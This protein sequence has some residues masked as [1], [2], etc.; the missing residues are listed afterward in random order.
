MAIDLAMIP[1]SKELEAV[2]ERILTDYLADNPGGD[3]AGYHRVIDQWIKNH[4]EE[5]ERLCRQPLREV[6]DAVF[7]LEHPTQ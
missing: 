2:V 6:A 1:M 4:P 7:W 3:E 5:V